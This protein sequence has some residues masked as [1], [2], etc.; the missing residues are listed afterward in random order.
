MGRSESPRASINQASSKLTRN[1]EII[2]R[3]SSHEMKCVSTPLTLTIS[4]ALEN[5]NTMLTVL[6]MELPP[7]TFLH[8]SFLLSAGLQTQNTSYE[9]NVDIYLLPSSLVGCR[10][11]PRDRSPS[12]PLPQNPSGLWSGSGVFWCACALLLTRFL[13]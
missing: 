4:N 2:Q 1:S 8:H 6:H 11:A 13:M 10:S 5:I 7:S 12:F 9:T 3:F